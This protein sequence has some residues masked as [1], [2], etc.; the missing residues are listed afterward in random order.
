MSQATPSH[1][2]S[3][4]HHPR[5][6]AFYEWTTQLGSSRRMSDPIR[7]ELVSKA[8]GV[9]LEIGA[10]TGLNFPFYTPERC[11]RVE[12]IEPDPAMIRY[13]NQ[14][15]KAAR[16]PITLT[17]ASIEALPFADQTFDSVVA[18]LVFCSVADPLQGF[19]EIQRVL[20]P[21]GVLLL[22]EHV[23][24]EGNISASIQDALVPLTTRLA[25]NCHWNRDTAQT[26]KDAGFQITE[27]RQVMK[28]AL[29]PVIAVQAQCH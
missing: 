25:G 7:Q 27:L 28:G 21:G 20:K 16:V 23:R 13:A 3:S 15:L 4:L 14:R 9:V 8:T 29:Q 5:F 1:T 24:S 22:L 11:E 26:V 19:R 12:A 10:G 18:T 6:A 2:D 17:P